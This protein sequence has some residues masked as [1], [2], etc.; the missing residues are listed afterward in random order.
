MCN[1]MGG[2]WQWRT[3]GKAEGGGGSLQATRTVVASLSLKN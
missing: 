3:E 1:I 2:M